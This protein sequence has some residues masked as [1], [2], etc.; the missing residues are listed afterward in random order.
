MRHVT[1]NI[2]PKIECTCIRS[3]NEYDLIREY[4]TRFP[5]ILNEYQAKFTNMSGKRSSNLNEYIRLLG[6]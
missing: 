1:C 6:I 3:S 2:R 5:K 4:G